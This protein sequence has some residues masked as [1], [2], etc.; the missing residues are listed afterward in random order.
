MAPE[1]HAGAQADERAD[2]FAFCVALYE[3]LYG[4]RPFDHAT[5]A[6]LAA[7]KREGRVVVPADHR[8]VPERLRRALLVGLRPRP[9]ER[10]ASMDELLTA[11]E[12]GARRPRGP[13]I[14]VASLVVLLAAGLATARATHREVPRPAVPPRE[15][16]DH[17]ACARKHGGEPYACRPADGVCVPMAT[18]DCAPQFEPG[19]VGQSSTVWLGAVLPASDLE[20][21]NQARR[22]IG[23]L[24]GRPIALVACSDGDAERSARHL[25]DDVGVPA[26]L[27]P[28]EAAD[29]RGVV[30][31][32]T[33][34]ADLVVPLAQ[35]SDLPKT[36][37]RTSHGL[38]T[39]ADATGFLLH[40]P[41]GNARHVRLVRDDDAGTRLFTQ[42]LYRRLTRRK[43]MPLKDPA[44]YKEVVL[45]PA[46]QAE[47]LERAAARVAGD[48]PEVVVLLG[49]ADHV[50]TVVA[51]IERG[52]A[53]STPPLYVL[54][55]GST[56]TLASFVGANA[57]RRRRVF[58]VTPGRDVDGAASSYDAFYLLA[59]AALSLGDRPVDGAAIASSLARMIPPATPVHAGPADAPTAL[60]AFARGET[61]DLT[62]SSDARDIDPGAGE[63][64]PDFRLVCPAVDAQ[65]RAT[66]DA[67]SG[68]S[69]VPRLHTVMGKLTCP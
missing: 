6:G 33:H 46:A 44:D 11:L 41:L 1:Q 2:V 66:G 4:V 21:V 55:G 43:G 23:S 3:G 34:T 32:R 38:E 54:P 9:E 7:D 39:L 47:E 42:K 57:D 24:H 36:A 62:G 15:C 12:R 22:E 13:V 20:V 19:D 8:G 69:Y 52:Y 16:D 58:A 27:G 68:V 18:P 5:V 49:A 53:G 64:A 30:S 17:A 10:Y 25:L 50:S 35:P 51:S 65:G 45:T 67:D 59:Y 61:V 60:A 14:A 31:V 37:W 48:K 40:K 28:A 29:A 63:W 26:L 56:A